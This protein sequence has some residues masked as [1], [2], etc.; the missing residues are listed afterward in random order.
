MMGAGSKEDRLKPVLRGFPGAT[1]PARRFL[2]A[3]R[4]DTGK[5]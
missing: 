2:D 4:S 5:K 1:H 3:R